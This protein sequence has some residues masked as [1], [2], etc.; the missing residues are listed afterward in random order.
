MAGSAGSG[1]NAV[2]GGNPFGCPANLPRGMACTMADLVCTYASSAG[3][4]RCRCNG[5]QWVC[6]G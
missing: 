5:M 4:V 6:P 1:G 2:D 3:M